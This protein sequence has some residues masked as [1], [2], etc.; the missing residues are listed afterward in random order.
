[1]RLTPN[2]IHN[3]EHISQKDATCTEAG[4]IGYWHCTD[5]DG[6]FADAEATKEITEED[7]VVKAAGHTWG[8]WEV[9]T[10]PTE[11]Q[12]GEE[13]RKCEKC[14]AVQTRT[15]PFEYDL[16][17]VDEKPA[18]CTEDGNIEYWVYDKSGKMFMDSSGQIEIHEDDVIISALGHEWGE[19]NKE[20]ETVDGK[21]HHRDS[22]TCLR[23]GCGVEE[24]FEYEEGHTHVCELQNEI[25]AT[26]SDTGIKAHYMCTKVRLQLQRKILFCQQ[27]RMRTNGPTL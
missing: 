5:C 24:V 3:L 26:C 7:T 11:E 9:T 4:N 20:T 22:R 13:T 10:E 16:R 15:V 19:W 6:Y 27:I 2:H 14:D 1:M 8:S 17:K 23:D 12:D 18:T 21:I 25:P